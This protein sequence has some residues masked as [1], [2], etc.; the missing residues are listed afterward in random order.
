MILLVHCN[1]GD[2]LIYSLKG[3]VGETPLP[4]QTPSGRH[5]FHTIDHINYF[6]TLPLDQF[7]I[8]ILQSKNSS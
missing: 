3:C 5:P 8:C 7:V 6:L 1:V 2:S 4:Q